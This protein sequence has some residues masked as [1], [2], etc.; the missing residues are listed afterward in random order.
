MGLRFRGRISPRS[1]R[2]GDGHE[3]NACGTVLHGRRVVIGIALRHILFGSSVIAGDVAVYATLD[4]KDRFYATLFLSFGAAAEAG[5][6]PGGVSRL[7][8]IA[9]VGPPGR[10]FRPCRHWR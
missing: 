10:F 2:L 5:A 9:Q 1:G 6:L 7:V 3:T 4:S 8:P